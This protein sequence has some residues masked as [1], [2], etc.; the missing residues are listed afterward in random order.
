MSRECGEH[1]TDETLVQYCGQEPLRVRKH[2]GGL[3]TNGRI[4]L[5]WIQ[6]KQNMKCFRIGTTDWFLLTSQ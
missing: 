3:E 6:K 1:R 2:F 4:I 5:M